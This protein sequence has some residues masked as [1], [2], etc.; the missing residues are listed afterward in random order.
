V[1]PSKIVQSPPPKEHGLR[2]LA[3][4]LMNVA[5]AD[6][7][8]NQAADVLKNMEDHLCA[9][10]AYHEQGQKIFELETAMPEEYSPTSIKRIAQIIAHKGGSNEPALGSSAIERSKRI[11]SEMVHPQQLRAE[12]TEKALKASEEQN[13]LLA[14][15]LRELQAHYAK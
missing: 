10:A 8:Y 1:K 11:F 14:Q 15:K 3:A 5:R 13:A 6:F 9:L 7:Y 12:A 2:A 4:K